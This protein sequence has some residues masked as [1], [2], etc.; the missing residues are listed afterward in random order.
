MDAAMGVRPLWPW[1]A[2][3]TNG[4]AAMAIQ[5]QT[6]VPKEMKDWSKVRR[7]PGRQ[8]SVDGHD[9]ADDADR[10]EDSLDCLA[11]GCDEESDVENGPQEAEPAHVDAFADVAAHAEVELADNPRGD[12]KERE[13]LLRLIV[14]ERPS[15]KSG[16]RPE[17][18]G[19]WPMLLNVEDLADEGD[20][21]AGSDGADRVK[22]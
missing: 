16:E 8:H 22:C 6:R 7:L 11:L 9:R 4:M 2:A 10:K 17:K 15:G 21:R 19:S 12:E 3:T 20:G 14:E 13:D 1:N 5:A 18:H